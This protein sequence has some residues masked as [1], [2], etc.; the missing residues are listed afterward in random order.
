MEKGTY[1]CRNFGKNCEYA[2]KRTKLN[3]GDGAKLTVD[4]KEFKCPIT[5]PTCQHELRKTG[6]ANGHGSGKR[7]LLIGGVAVLVAMAVWLGWPSSRPQTISV[8]IDLTAPNGFNQQLELTSSNVVKSVAVK[9]GPDARE[10]SYPNK[11]QNAKRL[12]I[13]HKLNVTPTVLFTRI[14]S[15]TWKEHRFG[16]IPIPLVPT[17]TNV[18]PK[19][20]TNDSYKTNTPLHVVKRRVQVPIQAPNISTNLELQ[21]DQLITKVTVRLNSGIDQ[22]QQNTDI[23]LTSFTFPKLV[24]SE[25]LYEVVT[26]INDGPPQLHRFPN[27]T[28]SVWAKTVGEAVI[29]AERI[30]ATKA[31][32]KDNPDVADKLEYWQNL[33]IMNLQ[34]LPPIDDKETQASAYEKLH[35]FKRYTNNLQLLKVIMPV[36]GKHLNQLRSSGAIST[37]FTEDILQAYK[38]H[39]NSLKEPR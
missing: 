18:P 23:E 7:W 13:R 2:R 21:T 32:L 11:E 8:V 25:D 6:G 36:L 37:N 10:A 20:N 35:Q 19:N 31:V 27:Y 4:G 38:S 5:H 17:N 12:R 29:A 34:A 1:Q 16:G 3:C 15:D 9:T 33:Y 30:A 39:P 24:T 28:A 14:N 26:C 22:T